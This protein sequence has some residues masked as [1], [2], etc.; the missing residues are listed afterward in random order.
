MRRPRYRR[1]IDATGSS[2]QLIRA[3]RRMAEGY[4]SF[5]RMQASRRVGRQA[6]VSEPSGVSG[7]SPSV[8]QDGLAPMM[9]TLAPT[10]TI[11]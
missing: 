5:D 6:T 1:A 9:I 4:G 3:H 11:S 8:A 7:R 2:A 10:G